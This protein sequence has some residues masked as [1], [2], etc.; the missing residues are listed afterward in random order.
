MAVPF[1]HTLEVDDSNLLMFYKKTHV[2][3]EKPKQL[4]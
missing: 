2:T 3:R 1:L 4:S